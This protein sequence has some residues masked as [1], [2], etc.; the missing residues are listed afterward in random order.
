M[1]RASVQLRSVR[2]QLH[3][4]SVQFCVRVELLE[5]QLETISRTL[6]EV[7]RS[8]LQ[9]RKI[10]SDR[11]K[12]EMLWA[13]TIEIRQKYNAMIQE[14]LEYHVRNKKQGR[15]RVAM[16]PHFKDLGLPLPIT[17]GFV[18]VLVSVTGVKKSLNF[19]DPIN[20][21]ELAPD[22]LHDSRGRLY[23]NL[24]S[25]S[26]CYAKL[27]SQTYATVW[28]W[29]GARHINSNEDITDDYFDWRRKGSSHSLPVSH[30]AGSSTGIHPI[31]PEFC[32][33]PAALQ[34]KADLMH[35]ID[36]PA[37]DYYNFERTGSIRLRPG[38]E[39]YTKV[40]FPL[41]A[42]LA[43]R[44]PAYQRLAKMLAS[45]ANIQLICN[46]APEVLISA[47]RRPT[48]PFDKVLPG[49]CGENGAKSL[50]ID[51][52]TIEAIRKL[53]LDRMSHGYSL[54]VALLDG[55]SWL[56]SLSR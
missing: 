34:G 4:D 7:R 1:E 56:S 25:F 54:A 35:E 48:P 41:Y 49:I 38:W 39:A 31:A 2:E 17:Y 19:M 40:E 11:K 26:Y 12:H 28:S 46:D 37:V 15:V 43:Q 20:L 23:T 36:N 5:E 21:A 18:N 9:V 27:K 10:V 14:S 13:T 47:N 6:A 29:P 55:A 32:L 42:Y 50:E 53:D 30:P 24:V 3:N 16:L 51:R 22:Q 33:W 44:T 52:E 45:G 8:T